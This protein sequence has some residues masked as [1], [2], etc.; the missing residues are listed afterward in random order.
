MEFNGKKSKVVYNPV[1]EYDKYGEFYNSAVFASKDEARE[2]IKAW[3]AK[4][5]KNMEAYYQ[6]D[7]DEN[8]ATVLY[9]KDKELRCWFVIQPMAYFA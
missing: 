5:I 3:I 8:G 2:A 6:V 1:C 4:S 7:I 9:K